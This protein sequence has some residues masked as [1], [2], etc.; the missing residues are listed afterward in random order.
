LIRD[1]SGEFEPL[2]LLSTNLGHTPLQIL[3]W[4]VQRWRMEVTFE[5]SRAHPGI[6]TQRQW[7]D[8]AIAR[9]TPA[10]FGLFSN[11]SRITMA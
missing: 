7:N 10:L 11:V 5:E 1:P 9:T 4:F 8:L 6:E 3:S 2:A